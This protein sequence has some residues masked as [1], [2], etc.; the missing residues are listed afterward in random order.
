M[1]P[2]ERSLVSSLLQRPARLLQR[3]KEGGIEEGKEGSRLSARRK[4]REGETR[5]ER[6]RTG[7]I[8]EKIIILISSCLDF[9]DVIFFSRRP[10]TLR[11]PTIKSKTSS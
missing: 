5:S 1:G 11:N 2:E 8:G 7:L 3:K 10:I 4:K 6:G 9:Y